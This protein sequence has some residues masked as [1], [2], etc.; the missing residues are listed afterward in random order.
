MVGDSLIFELRAGMSEFRV[1]IFGGIRKPTAISSSHAIFTQCSTD[2]QLSQ[3][4]I[5]GH[6]DSNG[7]CSA[8]QGMFA[9]GSPCSLGLPDE[10]PEVVLVKKRKVGEEAAMLASQ[11]NPDNSSLIQLRLS[12]LVSFP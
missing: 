12:E 11:C 10:H 5:N 4:T 6:N 8:H 9:E 1:H 3:K 7:G 2:S